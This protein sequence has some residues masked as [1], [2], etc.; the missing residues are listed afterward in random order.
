MTSK[1]RNSNAE[2]A[3]SGSKKKMKKNK[4]QYDGNVD[5]TPA[6]VKRLERKKRKAKDNERRRTSSKE[7]ESPSS[8]QPSKAETE[9]APSSKVPECTQV[10]NFLLD[11]YLLSSI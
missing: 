6:S 5:A 2:R 10:Y 9:A 3:L 7:K 4:R 11:F 1:K 8:Q